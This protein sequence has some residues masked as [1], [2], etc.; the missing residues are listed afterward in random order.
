MRPILAD[1]PHKYISD[2]LMN[3][4]GFVNGKIRILESFFRIEDVSERI[5]FIKKEYGLV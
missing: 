3:G 1:V 5:K 4:S 2:V